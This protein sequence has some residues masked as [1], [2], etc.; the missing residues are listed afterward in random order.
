M[1]VISRERE[2]NA[3]WR[4]RGEPWEEA[5]R[6]KTRRET[7][8]ALQ[9]DDAALCLRQ[10]RR[11]VIRHVREKRLCVITQCEN[12]PTV[13]EFHERLIG[14]FD[15]PLT[16]SAAPLT[17]TL[18]KIAEGRN[19]TRSRNRDYQILAWRNI[20][21]PPETERGR[22]RGREKYTLLFDA[23]ITWRLIFF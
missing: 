20:F 19:R 2:E 9:G 11:S 23:N 18:A 16:R 7:C 15:V 12:L 21:W 5:K 10:W 4:G 14:R 6:S 3:S 22:E 13:T 1:H 8:W 17:T